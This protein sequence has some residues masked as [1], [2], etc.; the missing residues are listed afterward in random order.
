ML[1]GPLLTK[2]KAV[3]V[4]KS[5]API[6]L[7][8]KQLVGKLHSESPPLTFF[9]ACIQTQKHNRSTIG[10]KLQEGTLPTTSPE[11]QAVR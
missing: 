6:R 1:M 4:Y 3:F 7:E 5:F 10:E 11:N 8:K 2:N 9:L